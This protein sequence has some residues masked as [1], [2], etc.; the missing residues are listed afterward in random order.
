MVKE[1]EKDAEELLGRLVR[2]EG[3][4]LRKVAFPATRGAP[5]RLILGQGWAVWVELKRA[6]GG[7]LSA[8]Q[9]AAIAD[10]LAAGQDARVV[11]GCAGVRQ[12]IQNLKTEKTKGPK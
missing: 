10:L 3:W 7:V 8:H 1:L 4:K 11:A 12:L 6:E 9:R 2:A 5:D